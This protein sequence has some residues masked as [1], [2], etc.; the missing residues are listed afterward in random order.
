M[1]DCTPMAKSMK[2]DIDEMRTEAD[3]IGMRASLANSKNDSVPETAR[4]RK[5]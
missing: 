2:D 3:L 4:V 1:E 5:F